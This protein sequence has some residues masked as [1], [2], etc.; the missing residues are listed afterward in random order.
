VARTG[1]P[2]N[3]SHSHEQRVTTAV[4]IPESL[5]ESLKEAAAARDTSVNHLL[6][7]GADYY[8]RKLPPLDP[9]DDPIG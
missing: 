4:R 1:R 7:R 8:L 6:V 2:R 5:F 3:D 9:A